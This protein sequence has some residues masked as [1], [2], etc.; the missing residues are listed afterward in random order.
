MTTRNLSD[1]NSRLEALRNNPRLHSIGPSSVS[2]TSYR[3]TNPSPS[4]TPNLQPCRKPCGRN[5]SPQKQTKSM[6]CRRRMRSTRRRPSRRRRPRL[7]RLPQPLKAAPAGPKKPICSRAERR[8]GGRR[9]TRIG[10]SRDGPGSSN[11]PPSPGENCPQA[12]ATAAR[13]QSTSLQEINASVMIMDKGTQQ[14]AAMV[15]E[16]TA[17]SHHLASEAAA[18]MTLLDQFRLLE[19]RLTENRSSVSSAA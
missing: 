6:G 1:P 2:T 3:P 10:P 14:N 16:Q 4:A 8:R 7:S 12:I 5:L 19:A 17:A 11:C 9:E 15:E 13:D 18:L